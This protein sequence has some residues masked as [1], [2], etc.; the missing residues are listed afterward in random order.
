[1]VLV[2]GAGGRVARAVAL[3]L[4]AHGAAVLAAGPD[5]HEVV[6][7]A[8][9]VAAQGGV[10]RVVEAPA[11]PLLGRDLVASAG[12]TLEPPSDA[13]VSPE[14]FR[15]RE[16]AAAQA[17]VLEG[18]LPPGAHVVVLDPERGAGEAERVAGLFL[19]AGGAPGAR[20]D[21][22]SA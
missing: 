19:P 6:T 10:A 9:L 16:E 20:A 18:L 4:S 17:R 11:P 14:A 15:A 8:G 3:R 7:T 21:E 5:I 22:A 12:A 1:V 2:L 13:V